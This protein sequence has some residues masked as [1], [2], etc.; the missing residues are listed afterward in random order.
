MDE[1][2]VSEGRRPVLQI[3]VLA[4]HELPQAEL[5]PDPEQIQIGHEGVLAIID[6]LF[7]CR[8][9]VLERVVREMGRSEFQDG[10]TVRL[11]RLVAPLR[12]VNSAGRCS[13]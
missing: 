12:G 1:G 5:V 11:Q 2:L 13:P 4:P 3:S 9:I 6:L 8:S 10:I 7:I